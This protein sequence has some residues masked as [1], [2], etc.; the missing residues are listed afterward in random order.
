[1][2]QPAFYDRILLP[3]DAAAVRNTFVPKRTD[4]N[5]RYNYT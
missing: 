1:M 3:L 2:E 5:A 4:N